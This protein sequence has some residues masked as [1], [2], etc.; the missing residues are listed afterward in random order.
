M[1]TLTWNL[2][3]YGYDIYFN[4]DEKKN[5]IKAKPPAYFHGHKT[6]M[7]VDPVANGTWIAVNAWGI[8]L[9]LLNLYQ[10]QEVDK[11]GL[12]SELPL[13]SR[14]LLIPDLIQYQQS[15]LIIKQLKQ[16][17]LSSYQPFTL[18]VFSEHL[19]LKNSKVLIYQ[20]DGQLL[21]QK[22]IPQPITS[23]SVALEQVLQERIKSYHKIISSCSDTCTASDF[24]NNVHLYSKKHLDYHTSHIP[25]KN[26]LSVCMHRNDAQ[27]QSLSVI[28]VSTQIVFL[29]S[30]GSPCKH[31]L[32]TKL[33]FN[34]N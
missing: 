14:G 24:D 5:R 27:T 2:N 9:C 30:D 18:C 22:Q 31:P 15:A 10:Q 12:I 7:P 6:I 8:C 34:L 19:D 25:D 13:I 20:W 11:T 23:S 29:Y 3:K 4:R 32:Q 16:L 1:C 17:N 33:S 26:H 28:K 21:K